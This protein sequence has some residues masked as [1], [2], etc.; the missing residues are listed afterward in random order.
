M[1]L[2]AFLESNATAYE[3][4]QRVVSLGYRSFRRELSAEGFFEP[5]KSTLD[6]GCGTG[7]LRDYLPDS[8]YLG[9][10]L[11][12]RYIAAARA[13]RGPCFQVW[14][15]LA[16]ADLPRRFDRIVCIGLL[17]HLDD[18]QVRTVLAGCRTRL[19]PGGELYVLDALRPGSRNPL[20][21]ALRASDN[22]DFV[23]PQADWDRLFRSELD[24]RA[25]RAFRQ[26]PFD[27]VFV[28]AV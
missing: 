12:P 26:W 10:D 6:L 18:E 28:R 23:R 27:Y 15:A 14:N 3:L 17:H 20:G 13:K 21:R 16:V 9:V 19:D 8:D 1:K 2:F 22:G 24:V 4:V 5:G 7:F 11:N 25:I